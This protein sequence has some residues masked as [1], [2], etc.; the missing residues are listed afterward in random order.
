MDKDGNGYIDPVEFEHSNFVL[1]GMSPMDTQ[2]AITLLDTEE[3]DGMISLSEFLSFNEKQLYDMRDDHFEERVEDF[4]LKLPAFSLENLKKATGRD[5]ISVPLPLSEEMKKFVKRRAWMTWGNFIHRNKTQTKMAARIMQRWL[6][7]LLRQG[8]RFW[9]SRARDE[10]RQHHTCEHIR[11]VWDNRKLFTFLMKWTWAAFEAKRE[12]TVTDHCKRLYRD[13]Q[14]GLKLDK[15]CQ[16]AI[17]F[18]THDI[19]YS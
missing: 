4:H 17:I 8:F 2:H 9:I 14:L 5:K 10:I 19:D 13:K 11:V 16:R 3:T 7:K 18:S 6:S 15:V 12:Q 1:Q